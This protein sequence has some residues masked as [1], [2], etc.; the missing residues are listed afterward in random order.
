MVNNTR[1]NQKKVS[2]GFNFAKNLANFIGVI[3][4]IIDNK[5]KGAITIHDKK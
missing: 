5:K 3:T 2:L 1:A 4:N